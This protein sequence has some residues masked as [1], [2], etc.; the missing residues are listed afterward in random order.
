M[1]CDSMKCA[2]SATSLTALVDQAWGTVAHSHWSAVWRPSLAVGQRWQ[3]WRQATD[4]QGFLSRV[5]SCWAKILWRLDKINRG[6]VVAE[7]KNSFLDSGESDYPNDAFEAGM[8]HDLVA[9]RLA[10]MATFDERAEAAVRHLAWQCAVATLN[11]VTQLT[12]SARR[13]ASE[14]VEGNPTA[15]L[16]VR[17][18]FAPLGMLVLSAFLGACYS[19]FVHAGRSRRVDL[20]AAERQVLGFDHSQLMEKLCERVDPP[21]PPMREYPNAQHDPTCEHPHA[22]HEA[23][24]DYF[25]A[26][27]D[28]GHDQRSLPYLANTTDTWEMIDEHLRAVSDNTPLA[29]PETVKYTTV[30]KHVDNEATANCVESETF[31]NADS[32]DPHQATDIVCGADGPSSSWTESSIQA[33]ASR[34]AWVSASD[35]DAVRQQIGQAVSICRHRHSPLTVLLAEPIHEDRC[36]EQW[37]EQLRHLVQASFSS[38]DGEM[39]S[40]VRWGSGRVWAVLPHAARFEAVRLARLVQQRWETACTQNGLPAAAIPLAIGI[41]TSA[42]VSRNFSGDNLLEAAERCLAAARMLGSATVKSIDVL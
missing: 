8:W 15:E 42:V 35:R 30:E 6:A 19:R 41:A 3:A 24:R 28:P 11:D 10:V 4:E 27:H 36:L 40:Y 26:Q 32:T 9:S 17:A 31:S 13:R 37:G 21:L 7:E 22:R 20:R 39:G 34:G 23:I 5:T 25:D 38:E 29:P 18:F 14:K 1:S 16:L 33:D 2:D 12:D